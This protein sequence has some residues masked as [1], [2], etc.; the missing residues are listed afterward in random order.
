MS[1]L[2]LSNDLG[3]NSVEI[4]VKSDTLQHRYHTL[5]KDPGK[6]HKAAMVGNIAKVKQILLPWINGMDDT[7]K[8]D[9]TALHSACANGHAGVVTL[10]TDR[11]CLWNLG[12][13]ANRTSLTKA[14]Q[15]QQ[16]ECATI[17]L[18]CGADTNIMDVDGNTVLHH[19]VLG[20]KNKY[21]SKAACTRQIWKQATRMTSRHCHLL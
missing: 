1:P 14:I 11:K 10:L 15:S 9:R 18:D 12:D 13:S 17:L 3:R 6:T 2:G 21:S 19:A 8:M 20:Q 7:D 4:G 5:D 16:E